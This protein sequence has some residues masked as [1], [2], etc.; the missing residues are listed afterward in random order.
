MGFPIISIG[1]VRWQGFIAKIRIKT[2]PAQ[3][4]KENGW[5]FERSPASFAQSTIPCQQV[6]TRN[7]HLTWKR[8]NSLDIREIIKKNRHLPAFNDTNRNHGDA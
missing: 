5:L 3:A 8:E 2:A 4:A 1:T 6:K 7:L